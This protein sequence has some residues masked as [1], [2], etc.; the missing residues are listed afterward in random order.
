MSEEKQSVLTLHFGHRVF[1]RTRKAAI[2][3]VEKVSVWTRI[4]VLPATR[5]SQVPF[6]R[7]HLLSFLESYVICCRPD[8]QSKTNI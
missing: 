3:V 8:L 4:I 2:G 7:F 6:I 5:T 1:T